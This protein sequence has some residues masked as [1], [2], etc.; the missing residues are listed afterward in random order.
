MK[1][2]AK[3]AREYLRYDKKTGKMY[4]RKTLHGKV[5]PGQEEGSLSH[6]YMQ[7]KI[8]YRVYRIHRLA[9]LLV[10]GDWPK[11]QIDHKNRNRA[12]NCW[13]NLREATQNQN[14]SNCG[15]R[16]HNTSGFKGACWHERAGRWAAHITLRGKTKYLGLHDTPEQAHAA[17]VRAAIQYRGEFA[18]AA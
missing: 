2:M 1:L 9:W 16:S 12:D 8:F 5:M 17:Y 6:G 10:T 4:W 11:N 18:R 15:K 13:T 14:N 3:T 7:I